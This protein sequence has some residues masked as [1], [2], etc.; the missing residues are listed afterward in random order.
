MVIQAWTAGFHCVTY[1]DLKRLQTIVGFKTEKFLIKWQHG[2][3]NR[4]KNEIST[5]E[6]QNGNSQLPSSIILGKQFVVEQLKLIQS[7][8]LLLILQV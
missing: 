3:T 5:L 8:V 1:A 4:P 7:I 2:S 6:E